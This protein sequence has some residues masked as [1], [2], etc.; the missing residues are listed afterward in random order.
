LNT[1][2]QHFTTKEGLADNTVNSIYE[3]K[4]GNIWF[5]TNGG[6]S[7]SDGKYF[8]NFTTQDGLPGIG[9]FSGQI[10]WPLGLKASV[11]EVRKRVKN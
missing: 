9:K 8:R 10:N 4:A 7:R 1:P 2:F 3:A 5:G 6:V 11:R